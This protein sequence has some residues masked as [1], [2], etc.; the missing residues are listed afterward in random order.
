VLRSMFNIITLSFPR[1]PVYSEPDLGKYFIIRAEFSGDLQS[2]SWSAMALGGICGSLLGGYTLSTFRIDTI[3]LLFSLLPI[4]QLLSCTCIE[5]VPS[6]ASKMDQ[7]G[8]E[9]MHSESDSI[10]SNSFVDTSK[11][12]TTRR[13]KSSHKKGKKKKIS[14]KYQ[15]TAQQHSSL[16]ARWRE[17]LKSAIFS[18]CRAF[19]QPIILR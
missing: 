10:P 7:N 12:Q 19:R 14:L 4:V 5:E 15:I 3:F 6:E 13:R 11:N 9:N 18:L 1:H 8:Q 2:L 16:A 17:S